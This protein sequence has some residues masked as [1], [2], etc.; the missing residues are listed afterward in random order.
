MVAVSM[1]ELAVS[2]LKD[3]FEMLNQ[4]DEKK[5]EEIREAEDKVDL[6]EDK[7][8]TYL[9]KLTAQPLT[10]SDS[11]QATELLHLIGD[12]ERISD[13]CSNIA[14]CQL[15]NAE[16]NLDTHAYLSAVKTGSDSDFESSY[17]AYGEKYTLPQG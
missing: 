10:E 16:E 2:S 6:Y 8:G 4:F 3:S 5:G 13:H 17:R 1:A 7:L 11:A 9:V 12:F 14:V 15:A